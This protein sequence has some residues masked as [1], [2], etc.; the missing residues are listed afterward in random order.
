MILFVNQ[1]KS[2]KGDVHSVVKGVH[3]NCSEKISDSYV[4]IFSS[5]GVHLNFCCGMNKIKCFCYDSFVCFNCVVLHYFFAFFFK[6]K[7]KKILT[8]STFTCIYWSSNYL[9]LFRGIKFANI[10]PHVNTSVQAHILTCLQMLTWSLLFPWYYSGKTVY[11]CLQ[12]H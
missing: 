10:F 5:V 4:F 1:T 8:E 12:E 7:R 11:L 9:R 6:C 2:N 3:R